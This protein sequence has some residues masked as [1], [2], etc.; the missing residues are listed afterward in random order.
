ML[1]NQKGVTLTVLVV[2]I[3]VLGILASV[4]ISTT[5]D[6][7]YDSKVKTYI[8]DMSMIKAKAETIYEKYEF[9]NDESQ[10]ANG[11]GNGDDNIGYKV[12]ISD[13][14]KYGVSSDES[15]NEYWYKWD[16]TILSN[17]GFSPEMLDSGEYYYVN[18]KS[19]EVVYSKGFKGKNSNTIYSLTEM[20]AYSN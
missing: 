15:N 8:T 4:T 3:I 14:D 5:T 2:T 1:K 12:N 18:Y 7:M 19:G 11:L 9:E 16:K 6:L 10:S 20:K 13:M 17:N